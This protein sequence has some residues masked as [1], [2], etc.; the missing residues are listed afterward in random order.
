MF[1]PSRVQ[2]QFSGLLRGLNVLLN[3][4]N[5]EPL[6]GFEEPG[7][8]LHPRWPDPQQEVGQLVALGTLEVPVCAGPMGLLRAQQGWQRQPPACLPPCSLPLRSAGGQAYWTP[9]CGHT[10]QPPKPFQLL[11]AG[12]M[13]S[14][15]NL[16]TSATVAGSP[17][18][19]VQTPPQYCPCCPQLHPDHPPQPLTTHLVPA[20]PLW[21]HL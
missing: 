11:L 17:H 21:Q 7:Q 18:P 6:R 8:F 1:S 20:R 14:I 19:P 13:R 10:S 5:M 12:L 9:F 3:P 15:L 4:R 16:S 2:M